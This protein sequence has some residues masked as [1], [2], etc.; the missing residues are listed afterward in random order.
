M[1]SFYAE[2]EAIRLRGLEELATRMRYQWW[3]DS[4]EAPIG[5]LPLLTNLHA[6]GI[7]L[8]KLSALIDAEEN[9]LLDSEQDYLPSWRILTALHLQKLEVSRAPIKHNEGLSLLLGGASELALAVQ[10]RAKE[11]AY[12]SAVAT[13]ASLFTAQLEAIERGVELTT[14][15]PELS[16]I[17]YLAQTYTHATRQ[18]LTHNRLPPS[19]HLALSKPWVLLRL[20]W[21]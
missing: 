17:R 6:Q 10:R 5:G 1:Y 2:L 9:R 12:K 21:A 7:P 16:K 8:A 19:M 13:S 3:R 4:L 20:V 11:S 15:V 14:G 18:A